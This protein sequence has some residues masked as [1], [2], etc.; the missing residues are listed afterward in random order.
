MVTLELQ[1]KVSVVVIAFSSR[2]EDDVM[3]LNVEPGSYV[4]LTIGFLHIFDRYSVFF[5]LLI[6][7]N[8]SASSLSVGTIALFGSKPG[9]TALARM[10]PVSGSIIRH[11][12]RFAPV[13]SIPSSIAFSA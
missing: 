7:S 9:V 4:S 11:M 1:L 10:S 8:F 3:S 6:F 12:I 13:F 2:A 5:L